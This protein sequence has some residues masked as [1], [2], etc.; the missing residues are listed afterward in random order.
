LRQASQLL[1]KK[2]PEFT[3]KA[4][5]TLFISKSISR[6]LTTINC[7]EN[8]QVQNNEPEKLDEFVVHHRFVFFCDFHDQPLYF[9]AGQ[10]PGSVAI[11]E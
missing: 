7:L 9:I 4:S 8:F 2:V 11:P 5:G 3:I 10:R 6:T 1:K